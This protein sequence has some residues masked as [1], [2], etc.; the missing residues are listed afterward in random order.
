[1]QAPVRTHM[2]AP[3]TKT[4]STHAH[5]A[6]HAGALPTT[7]ALRHPVQQSFLL[8]RIGGYGDVALRDF[9]LV[10]GALTLGRLATAH[11]RGQL[12]S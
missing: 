11:E 3:Q 1:M 7:D 2:A 12:P 9:G 4:T 5:T 6:P 8:L 10:L